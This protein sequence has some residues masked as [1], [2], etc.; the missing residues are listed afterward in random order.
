MRNT[1][2]YFISH[3]DILLINKKLTYKQ[4]EHEK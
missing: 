4:R 3:A 1:V 2:S